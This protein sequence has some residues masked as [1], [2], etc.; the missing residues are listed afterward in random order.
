MKLVEVDIGASPDR[1]G[2][3]RLSGVVRYDDP[4][5]GRAEE[6]YWLDFPDAFAGDVSASGNP[7]LAMLLPVAVVSNEPLVISRPVD[8]RLLDNSRETMHVWKRWF[9]DP[10]IHVEA[11]VEQPDPAAPAG[12]RTASFFSGEVDSFFTAFAR[13]AEAVLARA[14][15]LDP[16][17]PLV[18]WLRRN[19]T[20]AAWTHRAE[21]LIQ[22][23]DPMS[24]RR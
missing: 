15:R 21:A 22:D 6:T 16:F 20:L 1:R 11:D 2:H 8:A 18:R 7:W 5:G 23:V 12:A 4:R 9:G 13:A 3:T 24:F 10:V 17:R 19:P 14:R